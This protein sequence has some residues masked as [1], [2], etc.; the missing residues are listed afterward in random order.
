MDGD[1]VRRK[2]VEQDGGMRY[3]Y[4]AE[5]TMTFQM[6]MKAD[7]TKEM[8]ASRYNNDNNVN[9]EVQRVKEVTK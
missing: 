5:P 1:G 2:E 4:M 6:T 8:V 9:V 7:M 3:I